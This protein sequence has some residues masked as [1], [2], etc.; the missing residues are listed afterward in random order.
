MITYDPQMLG[1]HNDW[2]LR[3]LTENG[4]TQYWVTCND[5][6]VDMTG[7]GTPHPYLLD[8][9]Y[10]NDVVRNLRDKEEKARA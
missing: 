3:P 8:A 2:A 9:V 5:E 4:T 6:L 10:A 7:H 1:N